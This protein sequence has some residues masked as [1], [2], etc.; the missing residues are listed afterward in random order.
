MTRCH[1]KLIELSLIAKDAY[2]VVGAGDALSIRGQSFQVLSMATS[3][4]EEEDQEGSC[5]RLTFMVKRSDMRAKTKVDVD[6]IL[7]WDGNDGLFDD[8]VVSYPESEA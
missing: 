8:R 7:F 6:D 4:F 3:I 5:I 2:Y 1:D